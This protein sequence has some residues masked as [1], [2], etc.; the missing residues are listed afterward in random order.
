LTTRD[1]NPL[2][3]SQA[4]KEYFGAHG[5]QNGLYLPKD[6]NQQYCMMDVGGGISFLYVERDI[7]RR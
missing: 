3:W 1:W 2:H 7:S 4:A 6:K 5:S